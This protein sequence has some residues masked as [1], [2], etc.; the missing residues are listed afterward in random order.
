MIQGNIEGIR[1]SILAELE[2]LERAIFEPDQFLPIE[3]VGALAT[4]TAKINREISVYIARSGD[5]LEITVGSLTS[6][7]L[8]SLRLRRN[9][10]RLAKVRCVHTHPGGKT[11]LSDVDL[12]ALARLRLD[13][14]VSIGV[15]ADGEPTGIQVSFIGPDQT[16]NTTRVVKPDRIPQAAW[17]QAVLDSDLIA[18]QSPDE[19]APDEPERVMLLGIETDESLDELAQLVETAGGVVVAKALQKRSGADNATYFGKG[20]LEEAGLDAQALR[21][22]LIIADDELSGTQTRNIE[23]LLGVPVIVVVGRGLANG[24]VEVRPRSGQGEDV[25]VAEVLTKVKDLLN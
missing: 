23:K 3:M 7:P 25:P 12:Q 22:D 9:K 10:N 20:K 19:P 11:E 1:K 8:S 24:L 15:S 14:I 13:A 21:V 16:F 18:A 17:I 4:L 5:V 2:A 6:V